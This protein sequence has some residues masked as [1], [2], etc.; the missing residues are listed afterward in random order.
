MVGHSDIYID[1]G[2][3]NTSASNDLEA[4]RTARFEDGF[5]LLQVS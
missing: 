1:D 3:A 2:M 5:S 4:H